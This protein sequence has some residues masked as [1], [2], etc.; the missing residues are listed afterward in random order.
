MLSYGVP[1]IAPAPA[2]DVNAIPDMMRASNDASAPRISLNNIVGGLGGIPPQGINYTSQN[3]DHDGLISRANIASPI[4]R[5]R[6]QTG[7]RCAS[8]SDLNY[9]VQHC[10]NLMSQT[11]T[12]LFSAPKAPDND[13]EMAAPKP[14]QYNFGL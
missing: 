1:N 4:L 10:S 8:G 5:D 7:M 2:P 11:L 14:P 6:E 13:L 12:A 3:N 9:G